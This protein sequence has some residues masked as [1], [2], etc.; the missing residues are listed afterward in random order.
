MKKIFASILIVAFMAPSIY[1]GVLPPQQVEAQ[2]FGLGTCFFGELVSSAIQAGLELVQMAI[3][4]IGVATGISIVSSGISAATDPTGAA[5]VGAGWAESLIA[6]PVVEVNPVITS[7]EGNTSR[8]SGGTALASLG[9]MMVDTV[10]SFI[11][12]D[13]TASTMSLMFKEC[14]LDP[15]AWILKNIVI[16]QM[17][18]DI[19]GWVQSGFEGA[20]AFITD[21]LGFMNS[22][23]DEAVGLFLFESG[24]DEYLCSPFQVDVI[25]DFYL[26]YHTPTFGGGGFSRMACTLDDVFAAASG[27]GVDVTT[28]VNNGY[29]QLVRNG[30]L[31]FDGGGFNAIFSLLEDRNNPYG[32]YF[33]LQSEA[34]SRARTFQAKENQLLIQANGWFSLRC[35]LDGDGVNDNVCTPGEFVAKQVFSWSDS[36]LKQL[37]AAD[38][39]SE[40]IDAVI[41]GMVTMLLRDVGTGGLG[42]LGAGDSNYW[43]YEGKMTLE[44]YWDYYGQTTGDNAGEATDRGDPYDDS[45]PPPEIDLDVTPGGTLPPTTPAG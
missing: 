22:I 6:E 16:E 20:P 42:L 11:N 18:Q 43:D 15:L 44:E 21:P 40:I 17:A 31:Q 26:N 28:A 7:N 9:S 37:E 45:T 3:G 33:N 32:T 5:A 14:V 34:A 23:S 25:V 29:N 2:G 1:L 10:M 35:D 13:G 39:L 8:A 24:L 27:S 41:A 19:M 30:D 36:P 38:E 4:F 12:G